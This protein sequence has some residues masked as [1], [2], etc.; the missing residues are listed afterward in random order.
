[1]A[2]AKVFGLEEGRRRLSAPCSIKLFVI[3]V[4][5]Y[6]PAEKMADMIIAVPVLRLEMPVNQGYI[7]SGFNIASGMA[8]F[9]FLDVRHSDDKPLYLRKPHVWM[10]LLECVLV[11]LK[12]VTENRQ[13][14]FKGVWAPG[15]FVSPLS[16]STE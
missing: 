2:L 12:I 13:H 14:I 9:A 16:Q 6:V 5:P 1:M 15:I 4:K 8:V 3:P 7:I 11:P 10:N